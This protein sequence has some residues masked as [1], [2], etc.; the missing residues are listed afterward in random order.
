MLSVDALTRNQPYTVQF[1]VL[2]TVL[3]SAQQITSVTNR[4]PIRLAD[5]Q[6]NN[7]PELSGKSWWVT[8][9][10]CFSLF[11]HQAPFC[12]FPTFTLSLFT[13]APQ[14]I[15]PSL[16]PAIPLAR[17]PVQRPALLLTGPVGRHSA[18]LGSAEQLRSQ[19]TCLV[20]PLHF[21]YQHHASPS[22]CLNHFSTRPNN[23]PLSP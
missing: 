6:R 11:F 15:C 22:S 20:P 19:T 2:N 16:L 3:Y 9:C 12:Y 4:Q 13:S 23:L 17:S 5:V 18:K 8:L 21:R 1:D 7:P 14:S 10:V